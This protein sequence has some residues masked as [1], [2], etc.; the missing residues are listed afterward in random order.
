MNIDLQYSA[1]QN[2]KG[3]SNGKNYLVVWESAG[4]DSDG[5]GIR[6]IYLDNEGS[7]IGHEIIVNDYT[8][9]E[10]SVPFIASDGENYFVAWRSFGQD[11]SGTGVYGQLLDDSG[12]RIGEEFRLNSYT[13]GD[14]YGWDMVSDGDKYIALWNSNGQDGSAYGVYGT[15]INW[16]YGTSPTSPDSDND[17]ILDGDEVYSHITNPIVM[18]TDKDGLNDGDEVNIYQTDPKIN[19]TDGDG[20][21]DKSEIDSNL[22]PLLTDSYEDTDNDGLVNIKEVFYQTDPFNS[23]TDNDG[24]SDGYEVANLS[25]PVL[26]PVLESID[27]DNDGLSDDNEYILGSNI[28][29]ADTDNDGLSDYFDHPNLTGLEIRVNETTEGDQRLNSICKSDTGYL[30]TWQGPSGYENGESE[31][32]CRLYDTEFTPICPEFQVNTYTYNI[33]VGSRSASDGTNYLVVWASVRQGTYHRSLYGQYLDRYGTKIG[34]EFFIDGGTNALTGGDIASNGSSYFVVYDNYHHGQDIYG[35]LY[36]NEGNVLKSNQRINTYITNHQRIPSVI[37]DGRNYLV[38][39]QSIDQDG[40]HNGAYGRLY[41]NEGNSLT[42]EIFLNIDWQYS[43]QQRLRVAS[44]GKNYLVVWE[45]AQGDGDNYGIRGIYL[46]NEGSVI[47]REIIV[48]DYIQDGQGAPFACSDG[49]NYFVAWRSF[50]QDGSVTGVYGRLLDDSGLRIGE[51]FRLNSYTNGDQYGRDMVS[52][53]DKYIALWSSNGQD[54]SSYGV[55][56]TKVIWGYG[57]SPTNTDSDNDGKS[58]YF[59]IQ[60]GTNPIVA[61]LSIIYPTQNYLLAGGS[62][63]NLEWSLGDFIGQNITVE[64]SSDSGETWDNEGLVTAADLSFLWTVPDINSDTAKLRISGYSLGIFDM[65]QVDVRID[66]IDPAA[67]VIT[68]PV[69]NTSDVSYVDVQGAKEPYASV[70]KTVAGVST[71]VAN[72]NASTSWSYRWNL[73]Q[74]GNTIEFY[75]VDQAGNRSASQSLNVSYAPLPMP[76]NLSVNASGTGDELRVYWSGYN[77]NLNNISAY[78]VYIQSD[79]GVYLN[80]FDQLEPTDTVNRGIKQHHITGLQ[81][82][83]SYYVAVVGVGPG[84]EYRTTTPPYH[85]AVPVDIVPPE[86]VTVLDISSQSDTSFIVSWNHSS[87]Y[88]NDLAGYRIY[89]DSSGKYEFDSEVADDVNSVILNK[90]I[91]RARVTAFDTNGNE[92]VGFENIRKTLLPHPSGLEAAQDGYDIELNW[93]HISDR[94]TLETYVVYASKSP[95]TFAEPSMALGYETSISTIV[96]EDMIDPDS[97]NYY[98]DWYIAVTSRDMEHDESFVVSPVHIRIYRLLNAE[99][100]VE[101]SELHFSVSPV[102]PGEE[103]VVSAQ[104]ANMGQVDADNVTV[105][106]YEFDEEIGRVVVD[107][108]PNG[109]TRTVS[110]PN[111]TSRGIKLIG[112]VVDPDKEFDDIDE[113]NQANK[114]LQVGELSD[115]GVEIFISAADKTLIEGSNCAL[116]GSAYYDFDV[117]PGFRDFPVQ[118]AQVSVTVMELD[119]ENEMVVYTGGHTNIN[120]NFSQG[121]F[122]PQ[123]VGNYIV[124]YEV[125]DNTVSTDLER[126]LTVVEDNRTDVRVFAENISFTPENPGTGQQFT[127]TAQVFNTGSNPAEDIT[128]YFYQNDIWVSDKRINLLMPGDN[129]SVNITYSAAEGYYVMSVKVELDNGSMEFNLNN[130]EATRA[131]KVGNPSQE[132]V[133]YIKTSQSREVYASRWFGPNAKIYYDLPKIFGNEDFEAKGIDCSFELIRDEIKYFSGESKTN[134]SGSV[135]FSMLAP[136]NI[137]L[138]EGIYTANDGTLEPTVRNTSITLTKAPQVEYRDV[139]VFSENIAFDN[140]DYETTNIIGLYAMIDYTGSVP[141]PE[142]ETG[143]VVVRFNDIYPVGN[144]LSSF[145]IGETSLSFPSTQLN[146]TEIASVAWQVPANGAHIIQVETFPVFSQRTD[147]DKATRLIAI[148]NQRDNVIHIEK[149]QLLWEDSDGNSLYSPGDTVKCI[150]SYR[151]KSDQQLTG[152]EI[153]DLLDSEVYNNPTEISDS[154]YIDSM[155]G[156][157]ETSFNPEL[158]FGGGEQYM[159]VVV[160][161]IGDLEANEEGIVEYIVEVKDIDVSRLSE[162]I[163]I[164]QTDQTDPVATQLNETFNVNYPP[165]AGDDKFLFVAGTGS[166]IQLD[167]T[168]SSDP[169]GGPITYQW[170]THHIPSGSAAELDNDQSSTPAFIADMIGRYSFELTVFDSFA[171]TD[172]TSVN[173]FT[174]DSVSDIDGDGIN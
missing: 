107:S 139:S 106:F 42:G 30:V 20:L 148:G 165:V 134:R 4:G 118:G 60:Q 157:E 38:V 51:E 68:Y 53:G 31:I 8:T 89:T 52:D 151:N 124:K 22:N 44:N 146:S 163:A 98:E 43:A 39:W 37:S 11:G 130:N 158:A 61:G 109:K 1:Q 75:Q 92:S 105:A 122:V 6:G 142:V 17:G 141:P 90:K 111:S 62:D 34:S 5:Y 78:R 135:G 36:D 160:W 137:G 7:I 88:G 154:G 114:I 131:V 162:S 23:D 2:V 117:V 129:D 116:G 153:F 100:V 127:V 41:D 50:G 150:I 125:S 24:M 72:S 64:F 15:K 128:V 108:I 97:T 73:A 28:N 173:I 33:Q 174:Y 147:N 103:F 161:D 59:E 21:D 149:T 57:T 115:I 112:V 132:P 94:S 170:A 133:F 93:T 58:D 76:V 14:Q 110:I 121:F 168:E 80:D 25:S 172:S 83:E 56:G 19:D 48:N 46:D 85:H 66:N 86:D 27:T 91:Y 13:N 55:Y 35:V 54:G 119:N 126:V 63:I 101:A 164:A 69:T 167:A 120:G 9:G 155:G 3:A 40:S 113:N 26:P 70:W 144:Q 18:D 65:A 136:G 10:Q 32:F 16:G 84:G 166:I 45:S 138:Y 47:G 156:P 102:E 95:F 99:F 82:G 140:D 104:I 77:E 169:E 29:V 159:N 12:M 145:Q 74:G 96:L 79:P 81:R 123:E 152:F 67:P 71:K 143:N 171:L 49:E 87:D